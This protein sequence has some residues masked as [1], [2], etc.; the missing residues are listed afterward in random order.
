MAVEN[1]N[2]TSELLGEMKRKS[3]RMFLNKHTAV[4]EGKYIV[5]RVYIFWVIPIYKSIRLIVG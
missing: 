1:I 5:C 4:E 3:G 2:I